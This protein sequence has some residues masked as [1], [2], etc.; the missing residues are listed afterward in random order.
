MLFRSIGSNAFTNT[1]VTIYGYNGTYAQKYSNSNNI[2]FVLLISNP[3]EFKYEIECDKNYKRYYFSTDT[4]FSQ[5]GIRVYK[6]YYDGSRD[7]VTNW[8]FTFSPDV[9]YNKS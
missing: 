7:E 6:R 2:T 5:E 4:S 3:N 1:S 9:L 8:D